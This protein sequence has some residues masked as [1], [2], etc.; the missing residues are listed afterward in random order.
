M[1]ELWQPVVGYEGL[2]E[3]SDQGRVRRDGSIRKPCRAGNGYWM[4]TLSKDGST[5][6]F[7]VHGLVLTVF[8]GPR[9]K[10]KQCR[11]GDGNRANNALS[12][13]SWGTRL[14]NAADKE[15]HGTVARGTKNGRSKLT[16]EDV[17]A[18]RSSDE[19]QKVLA[20]RYGVSRPII[21]RIKS[22]K[23][24]AS[25]SPPVLSPVGADPDMCEPP[26]GHAVAH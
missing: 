21:S 7:S 18:I 15:L 17:L 5:K 12:N 4:V 9:P 24:W 13:L 23:L 14:E 6:T 10:G 11:H 1:T 3:V 25:I 8:V 2:Y 20:E 22:G 16:P 19:F 26:I